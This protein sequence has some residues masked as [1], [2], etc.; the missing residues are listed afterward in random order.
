MMGI[1]LTEK[2]RNAGQL[3]LDL[4]GRRTHPNGATDTGGRWYP[5][6]YLDC[7]KKIRTPSRRWPW[8]LMMHCRTMVHVAEQTNY[9]LSTIRT[10]VNRIRKERIEG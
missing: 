7:C 6:H 10:A 1:R 5:D 9:S 2:L 4:Q 3:Y 8:S